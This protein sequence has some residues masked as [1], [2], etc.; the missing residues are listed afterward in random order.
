MTGSQV[1][2]LIRCRRAD[3]YGARD[4][5]QVDVLVDLVISMTSWLCI[6]N[7]FELVRR[8]LFFG[9]LTSWYAMMSPRRSSE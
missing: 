7:S 8:M 3:K 2:A 9:R 5:A 4:E 1:F 6:L